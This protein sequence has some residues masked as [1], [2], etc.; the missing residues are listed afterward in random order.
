MELYTSSL[1][2]HCN[3]RKSSHNFFFFFESRSSNTE[4][5]ISLHLIFVLGIPWLKLSGL[6]WKASNGWGEE[7]FLNWINS[8]TRV[9]REALASLLRVRGPSH[10]LGVL[11][12]SNSQFIS[13]CAMSQMSQLRPGHWLEEWERGLAPIHRKGTLSLSR[14]ITFLEKF[15]TGQGHIFYFCLA[16]CSHSFETAIEMATVSLAPCKRGCLAIG[17]PPN[18][19]S[20]AARSSEI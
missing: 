12:R 2:R 13:G 6:V 11:G 10:L 14:E 8:Y 1:N 7:I 16:G 5:R 4:W 18:P 9:R 20:E 19:F 15:L 17:G 3:S